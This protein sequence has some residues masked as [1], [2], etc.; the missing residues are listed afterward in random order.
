MALV[1]VSVLVSGCVGPSNTRQPSE[2]TTVLGKER[3]SL[4]TSASSTHTRMTFGRSVNEAEWSSDRAD[5]A[6]YPT[7]Q[8][9]VDSYRPI[10]KVDEKRKVTA[11]GTGRTEVEAIKN[12]IYNCCTSNNCDYVAAARRVVRTREKDGNVCFDVSITGFPAVL[13]SVQ[14][15]K[16]AFYEEQK[17]GSL[18]PLEIP[19][20]RYVYT[21][22]GM[23][24]VSRLGD[25]VSQDLNSENVTP[26]SS[27]KLK[28]VVH[29]TTATAASVLGAREM[30]LN[31]RRSA[32]QNTRA[33]GQEK[34]TVNTRTLPPLR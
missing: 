4:S 6:V 5:M 33:V 11:T 14:T 13:V 2:V 20:H 32:I 27:L 31:E 26:D 12:A 8:G 21:T 34:G 30:A 25:Q 1:G 23:W 3:T 17:D 10:Y 29:E 9:P 15:V 28:S 24:R 19:E 7:T 16:A 22:N 18:R